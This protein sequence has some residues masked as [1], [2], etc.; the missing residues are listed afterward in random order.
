MGRQPFLDYLDHILGRRELGTGMQPEADG[1]QPP[2]TT[3]DLATQLAPD[4]C[5]ASPF[6]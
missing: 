4:T 2:L 1:R 3:T 5:H 6:V